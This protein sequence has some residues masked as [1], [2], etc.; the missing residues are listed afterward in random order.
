[1]GLHLCHKDWQSLAANLHDN[2]CKQNLGKNLEK[3]P[4]KTKFV[5]DYSVCGL[6]FFEFWFL[7]FWVL[8]TPKLRKGVFWIFCVCDTLSEFWTQTPKRKKKLG[9]V[10]G[11]LPGVWEFLGFKTQN[12]HP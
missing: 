1:M 7:E 10:C 12:S 11:S 5:D 6:W 3:N 4:K 9:C 8:K 2:F